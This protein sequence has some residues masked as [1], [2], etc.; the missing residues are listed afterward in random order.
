MVKTIAAIVFLTLATTASA[1]Q[2]T[3]APGKDA[4]AFAMLDGIWSGSATIMTQAG[5]RRLRHT[6]RVGPMLGGAI[7]VIEGKSYNPD[8][9]EAGFNA[10]AVIS[11]S[12]AGG[13]QFRSYAQGQSGTFPFAATDSGF[14]WS[15]QAG[16]AIIRYTAVIKNGTWHEEG[17]MER[18]GAPAISVITLD[19]KR[20]ADT[21]WPA[22]GA[23]RPSP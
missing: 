12:D 6:E 10:F 14:A 1:Q 21:D 20:V 4:S 17:M 5:P 9:S 23:V 8:G 11:A 2:L 18:P 13:Y 3:P 7:R 16:P 15:M 22:A 19:L